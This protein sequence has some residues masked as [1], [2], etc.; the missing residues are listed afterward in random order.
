MLDSLNQVAAAVADGRARIFDLSQE[1]RLGMPHWPTHPPFLYSLSKGHGDIVLEG[2]VSSAAEVMTLGGH[3]GTHIDALGHFSRH[4]RLHGG[5]EAAPNQSMGNGLAI[6]GIDRVLPIVRRGV[7]LDVAPS[8][9][10][11]LA[12]SQVVTAEHLEAA[13]TRAAVPVEPGDVVLVR[14]GWGRSWDRPREMAGH[15][16]A[17]GLDLGAA[18]WLS[19]R[20]IFAAGSDTLAF[21]VTPTSTFPVHVH[22]LV[23]SGIHIMEALNLEPLHE[24]GVHEF[25]FVASP[26]KIRGGTGSPVRPFAIA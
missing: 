18:Q 13:A 24:A 26:L 12:P 17:P 11:T 10:Q 14:T 6:A 20:R 9:M 8:G 19:T 3:L 22:L 21:E 15:G 5:V 7:L 23:D 1:W 4:G 2:G 16:G 25:L